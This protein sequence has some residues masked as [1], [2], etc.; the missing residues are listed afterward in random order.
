MFR[1][2]G[3]LSDVLGNKFDM[4]NPIVLDRSSKFGQAVLA[5]LTLHDKDNL[6]E[7]DEAILGPYLSAW[8][9]FK[10]MYKPEFLAIEERFTDETLGFTG[11]PDRIA[12][13]QGRTW[14]LD[15]KTG[16][17]SPEQ[18]LQT[19]AYEYLYNINNKG[20]YQLRRMCIFLDG[21]GFNVV[22][23]SDPAD[24]GVFLSMLT[25][26]KWKKNNNLGGN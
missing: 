19:A 21:K 13:M 3:I 1:V 6:G 20:L 26:A 5:T 2:T 17:K 11:Q 25:V 24:R 23:Y 4:V 22:E 12:K 10:K 7:Y 16:Q 18:A 8:V 14:V 9:D 15:F